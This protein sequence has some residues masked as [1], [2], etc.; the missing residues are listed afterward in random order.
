VNIDGIR[1]GTVVYAGKDRLGT[2][3]L[4]IASQTWITFAGTSGHHISFLAFA[5]VF[6]NPVNTQV[7]DQFIK[8]VRFLDVST[9]S[10]LGKG[11]KPIIFMRQ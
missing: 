5:D 4:T 3:K 10:S 2:D 7:R 8:T 1:T 9:E 6:D 11:P